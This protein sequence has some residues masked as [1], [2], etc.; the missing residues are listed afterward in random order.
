[1]AASIRPGQAVFC[2][3]LVCGFAAPATAQI[4]DPANA[5]YRALREGRNEDARMAF[6]AAIAGEDNPERRRRMLLDLGYLLKAGERHDEAAGAFADAMAITADHRGLMAL[7]YARLAAG[8]AARALDAFEQA[9]RLAPEDALLLRQLGYLYKSAGRRREASEAFRAAI[10]AE[11]AGGEAD[12][13]RLDLLRR[14]R[15]DL[16]RQDSGA[17]LTMLWRRDR[18]ND[19][20]LVLGNPVLSRSQGLLEAHRRL[21]VSSGAPEAF[22]RLIWQID[23][24]DPTP[25]EDSLQAGIGLAARPFEGINL[26]LAAERLIAIGDA[27]RDDWLARLS[28]SQG[29]GVGLSPG[30]SSRLF[31]SLYGDAALIDPARP[32]LQFGAEGRLGW[33]GNLGGAT[34]APHLMVFALFQ[35]DASGT[36]GIVEAGPSLLLRLPFGGSLTRAPGHA[37]SLRLSYRKKLAGDAAAANGATLT[38][39]FEF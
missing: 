9:R 26:V 12:V 1:M 23:G 31:W 10:L 15:R 14:E 3:L 20:P 38:L 19:S 32:D 29:S 7:G 6:E 16:A 27:A 21:P 37:I 28:W 11:L 24:A 17:S 33:Q 8:D 18:R 39:A 34:L 22:A 36:P 13:Q 2:F 30:Q 25:A 5:A 4:P 35:D